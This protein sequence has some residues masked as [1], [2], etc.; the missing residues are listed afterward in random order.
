[1]NAT[2]KKRF[3]EKCQMDAN[4]ICLPACF[5]SWAAP[6]RQTGIYR[7]QNIRGEQEPILPLGE[8]YS[9]GQERICMDNDEQQSGTLR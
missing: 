3:S 4:R 6:I 9:S 8:G 7:L 5:P 2:S 1:L